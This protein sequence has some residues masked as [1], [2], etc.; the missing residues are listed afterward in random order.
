MNLANDWRYGLSE[1]SEHS[2]HF[3]GFIQWTST[4][5]AIRGGFSELVTQQKLTY[6]YLA[7]GIMSGICVTSYLLLLACSADLL[8]RRLRSVR[9]LTGILIF[10]VVYF[11]SIR[12]LWL[13]PG[14][15]LSIGA[16]TGVANGGLM[17]QFVLVFPLW[18]PL[19]VCHAKRGHGGIQTSNEIGRAG[20]S[21]MSD[22]Q[23]LWEALAK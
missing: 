10:E 3:S 2:H 4:I 1:E 15:G 14:G 22:L 11:F 9:L 19:L 7:F 6:F 5:V 20:I 18:G 12:A 23:R 8:R 21:Q 17:A 13:I 16:A